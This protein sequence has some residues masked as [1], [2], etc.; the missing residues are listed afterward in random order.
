MQEHD[1]LHEITPLSDKDCLY[2]V[3]R[4]KTEFTF[5]LHKHFE[6]ELNYTENAAGARRT[7][8]DSVEVVD[9]YDLVLITGNELE[10]VWENYHCSSSQIRE[11]T[12]QF[13]PDLLPESLLNKNPLKSIK[14]M[15][16]KA[17]KGLAFSL[18]T[19]LTIRPFLNSLSREKQ[20]FHALIDFLCLLYE[21][22]Q[23]DDAYTLASGSFALTEPTQESQRVKKVHNYLMSHYTEEIR[24]S[25]VASLV[26]MSEVS[27]SRFFKLRTGKCFSDY[28]IDIRIG[29]AIRL[30]VD[31][32]QTISEI[33][34]KSGF[35]NISNFNRI[36]KKW[37]NCTPKEFR[38]NYHKTKIIV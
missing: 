18:N 22:S 37:K 27:F 26:G 4:S 31:S 28:L 10:H 30:L 7:V 34:F 33:C 14:V 12:I 36:F 13:S 3:E 15:L 38:D 1:V 5:P 21:L 24:L 11:I 32:E 35:N 2:I 29:S 23:S 16:E 19:I 25:Q 9:N 6:Y 17:Q 8:G 20:S